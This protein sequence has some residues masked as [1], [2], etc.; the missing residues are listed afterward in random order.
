M[1]RP[2]RSQ[3]FLLL[4]LAAPLYYGL[5][6]LHHG[7][8]HDWIVQDDM[9]QHVVWFQQFVDAKL[10]PNDAIADYF[11][12]V[13]PMGVQTVYWLGAKLG[14][15]PLLLAKL[16]P[17]PLALVATGFMFQTT[18]ALLPVP[19]AAWL[20]TLML[21]QHLWLND[22]LVSATPRAFVYPLFAAFLSGLVRHSLGLTL[23]A[24]TLLGLFFPQMLLVALGMVLLQPWQW[25]AGLRLQLNPRLAW[26]VGLGLAVSI[27][28]LLPFALNLS[29]SGPAITTQQ[30]RVQP[31]YGLGGRNQY[32]GVSLL[33]FLLHGSSGLRIPVFPSLIWAGFALPFL[34]PKQFP[35]L[36]QLTPQIRLLGDLAIASSTLYILAHL[37][38]LRLHFPS[39]YLYH[40]WR[41]GLS[42]A[43]GI[44]LASLIERGFHW[45]R[46]TSAPDTSITNQRKSRQR[47]IAL[48]SL[49]T[50]TVIGVPMF[51]PLVFAFQGWVQGDSP[52]IYRYLARQPAQIRI[53]SLSAETNNLP[54]FS[55]RSSWTGRE[56]SLPHH[57][58]YY[59]EI[60]DR[61]AALL[62]AQYSPE[63]L[64]LQ[65]LR[66]QAGIDYFLIDQAAF[67]PSY[68]DQDWLLHSR[69]RPQ[70]ELIQQQL[71]AGMQPA[72][73]KKRDDCA[74]V[75]TKNHQL[76]KAS[77]L[78]E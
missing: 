36:R 59:A 58:Q 66:E 19:M 2:D 57:P 26:L 48:A 76:L 35:L 55:Q 65:Q 37:L 60:C 70:V 62:Q 6:T 4:S 74:I 69:L 56:F 21:N 53:A 39:R 49:A 63:Q 31:E 67:E 30:M 14:I 27:G 78:A 10:F 73:V 32:F 34:R 71:S 77:C 68:L 51:P 43:A 52:E 1:K 9:R 61:T 54:A 22:D 64:P 17:L 12:S 15:E 23:L 5:I 47:A 38:L 44:V 50:A 16:L 18:L 42:I 72:I 24:I 45:L 41:F 11:R 25:K 28:V 33:N 7:L 8:S 3:G 29:D 46:Q 20:T 40:S 13:S 75:S